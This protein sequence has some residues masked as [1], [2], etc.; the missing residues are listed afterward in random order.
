MGD[1]LKQYKLLP[2]VFK[3]CFNDGNGK[4]L[5]STIQ[6]FIFSISFINIFILFDIFEEINAYTSNKIKL[7]STLFREVLIS[8]IFYGTK[9]LQF[10]CVDLYKVPP[11]TI[12]L[13]INFLHFKI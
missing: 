3:L 13:L 11:N 7:N 10:L 5:N 12:Y 2:L 1:D 6:Y 4:N 9:N 8:K